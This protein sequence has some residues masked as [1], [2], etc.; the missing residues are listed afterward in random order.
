TRTALLAGLVGVGA[1]GTFW[2]NSRTTKITAQIF[3]VTERGHVTDRYT[4]ATRML[5][6]ESLD[7]RLA[8]VY[9]LEQIAKDTFRVD[10]DRPT[11]VAVLSAFVRVHSDPVHQFKDAYP[12]KRLMSDERLAIEVPDYVKKCTKAPDDIQAAVTVLGRLRHLKSVPP[13]D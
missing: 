13:A 2:L 10:E 3:A 5:A 7:V 8:G 1:L 6:S 9:A 4:T 12:D 11:I